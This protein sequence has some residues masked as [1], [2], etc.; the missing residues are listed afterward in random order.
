MLRGREHAFEAYCPQSA[1]VRERDRD[2]P[3]AL[4]DEARVDDGDRDHLTMLAKLNVMPLGRRIVVCRLPGVRLPTG[5]ER[6]PR[7]RK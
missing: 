4:E 5:T 6:R 2:A 7:G 3:L 1:T